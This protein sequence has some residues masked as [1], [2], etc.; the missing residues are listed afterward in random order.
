MKKQ[1]SIDVKT[2]AKLLL[3]CT[4][5]DKTVTGLVGER[6][7]LLSQVRFGISGISLDKIKAKLGL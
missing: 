5:L 2:Q 1:R 7:N 6:V 3:I 4:A